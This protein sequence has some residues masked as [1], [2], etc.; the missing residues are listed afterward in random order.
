LCVFRSGAHRSAI[1]SHE[2]FNLQVGAFPRTS[3][4]FHRMALA[5]RTELRN[6]N[7]LFMLFLR[8]EITAPRAFQIVLLLAYNVVGNHFPAVFR[9]ITS[10][11]GAP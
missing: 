3:S 10:P 8:P 6:S 11:A 1:Y 4:H 5:K 7:R 9:F 2:F